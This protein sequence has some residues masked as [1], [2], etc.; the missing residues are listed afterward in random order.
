V[1]NVT[2][3]ADNSAVNGT[4][5]FYRV[6][7][8]NGVGEGAQSNEV[9][10][11]P[12]AAATVP[13]APSIT[14]TAGNSTVGLSWS[15]PANGGSAITGYKVYR[16]TSAG[17]ETL[18]ATVGNVT[19]YADNSAVNGTTYFYRVAA[20]NGVGEGAQSNEVSATPASAPGA[21]SLSASAGSGTV[22]LSWSAPSNGGS[23]IT[24]Y[25]VYRGTSAGSETLLQTVGNVTSYDDNTVTGV[26]TYFYRVAAVNGVGEG[27]QSNEVSATPAVSSAAFPRT[28]VLDTFA[29]SAGSLGANWQSPGLADPG[30]VLIAA[31]GSTASNSAS[32]GSATWNLSLGADQEA[33]LTVPVLPAAGNFL[34]VAARVSTQTPSTLSCYF[35]R[36]IP[37]SSRFELRKKINGAGST[38]ITSFTAPFAAGDAMGLQVSGFTLTAYRKPGNGAWVPVGSA[39]DAAI[40][41]GGYVSFTL[42]DTTTRGAT[43]GGGTI[44]GG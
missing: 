40:A 15:A 34:Q 43:F 2:V 6:A 38:L 31:S 17:T 16:G 1:G 24:G 4:T 25:K 8:V 22:A 37:S 44:P 14:A 9:S 12:A 3:Y 41:G 18:L 28:G 26:T 13:A 11:T 32:A 7:A 20:V 21:P 39:T 33:Y 5:Y 10:A 30:T 19:V 35:L 36:V 27:A 23:S 29:R 42:G